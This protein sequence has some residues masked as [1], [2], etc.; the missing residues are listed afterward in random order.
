LGNLGLYPRPIRI[1]SPA[2]RNLMKYTEISTDPHPYPLNL[3]Q[4][5]NILIT[6]P[7]DND[8]VMSFIL[9]LF[10]SG[11]K[12]SASYARHFGTNN[13]E[14]TISFVITL[15]SVRMPC[16]R[17]NPPPPSAP[18]PPH[19]HTRVG[20]REVPYSEFLLKFVDEFTLLFKR[21]NEHKVRHPRCVY[22]KLDWE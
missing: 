22:N 12:V 14:K 3:S 13:G 6:A 4:Q 20:F 8:Y 1:S 7:R 21:K 9:A 5:L 17:S 16:L 2:G 11:N 19:T 18:P 15:L 10:I